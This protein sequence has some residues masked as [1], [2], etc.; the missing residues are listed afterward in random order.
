[1]FKRV[2]KKQTINAATPYRFHLDFTHRHN[3]CGCYS[4][5]LCFSEVS[6]LN[7][8]EAILLENKATP[9]I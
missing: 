6:S 3:S 9:V 4:G 8:L 7:F 5:L 2:K 1:M